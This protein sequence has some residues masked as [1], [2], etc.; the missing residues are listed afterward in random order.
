MGQISILYLYKWAQR[1]F[2]YKIPGFDK[3]QISKQI[4]CLARLLKSKAFLI[5]PEEN[6]FSSNLRV[7]FI[8]F[9]YRFLREIKFL[10]TTSFFVVVVH[11]DNSRKSIAV[12]ITAKSRWRKTDKGITELSDKIF[13]GV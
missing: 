1:Q 3:C 11:Y 6:N 7:L 9:L 13:P 10:Y 4:T 5:L 2:P 12:A 8:S